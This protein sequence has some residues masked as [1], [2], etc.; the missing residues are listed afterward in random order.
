MR[1]Y[2]RLYA[3]DYTNTADERTSFNIFATLEEAEQA[4]QA[5]LSDYN[6]GVAYEK[7]NVIFIGEFNSIFV[8]EEEDGSLNYEDHA[9]LYDWEQTKVVKRW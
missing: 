8:Y 3:L 7:P 1:Q 5:M 6:N 2:R 9:E 4:G